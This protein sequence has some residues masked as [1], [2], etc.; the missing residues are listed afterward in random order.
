MSAFR[1]GVAIK[2]LV[3]VCGRES[4]GHASRDSRETASEL[5]GHHPVPKEASIKKPLLRIHS[6][7]KH[8]NP[9]ISL[10]G[11][12]KG[13]ERVPA[14]VRFTRTIPAGYPGITSIILTALCENRV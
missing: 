13:S 7:S 3:I 4:M 9:L 10:L 2:S 12:L 1:P 8:R 14:I 6:L 11:N 5:G